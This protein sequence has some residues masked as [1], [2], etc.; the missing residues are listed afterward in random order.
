MCIFYYNRVQIR[1]FFV[2]FLLFPICELMYENKLYLKYMY[3]RSDKI[4]FLFYLYM[5]WWLCVN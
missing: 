5:I 2:V 4:L 3:T 1:C